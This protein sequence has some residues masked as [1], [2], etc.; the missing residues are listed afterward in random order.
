MCIY[1]TLPHINIYGKY[2]L[3]FISYIQLSIIEQDPRYKTAY[4][5][6]GKIYRR[7]KKRIT[8]EPLFREFFNNELTDIEKNGLLTPPFSPRAHISSYYLIEYSDSVL[9]ST[10]FI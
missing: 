5:L 1:S 8:N 3:R 4:V 2:T 7:H 10:Y 6:A 9:T